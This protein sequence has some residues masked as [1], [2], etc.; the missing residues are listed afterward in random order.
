[1]TKLVAF[2]FSETATQSWKDW[3]TNFP[4]TSGE[5]MATF[6]RY[7]EVLRCRPRHKDMELPTTDQ[8]DLHR[9]G[10]TSADG[11]PLGLELTS[12]PVSTIVN[13]RL[14]AA[15]RERDFGDGA[16]YEEV[17][18]WMAQSIEDSILPFIGA[19][20]W[21]LL[22]ASVDE[23]GEPLRHEAFELL[24]VE[25]IQIATGTRVANT[26]ALLDLWLAGRP[27]LGLDENDRLMIGWFPDPEGR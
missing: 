7:Q 5:L 10:A 19:D 25:L 1:V 21:N 27:V 24:L 12:R 14:E 8:L 15:L 16:S 9:L 17:L 11:Y 23:G 13:Q 26:R 4:G 6:R 18:D 20:G 2:G 3:D 22:V